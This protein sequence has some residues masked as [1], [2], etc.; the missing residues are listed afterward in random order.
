[1]VTN[2]ARDRILAEAGD[3][4]V[5]HGASGVT[6]RGLAARIG[7][8]PMALYRHFDSRE[9]LLRA[10]VEEGHSTFLGYLSRA[11]AEPTP[12]A[13]FL[14]S[15]LEYLA[16]ALDHPRKYAVM[17]MEHVPKVDGEDAT[18]QWLDVATFR[19]LV[20]RIRDCQA[21]SALAAGDP[22][23]LGLTVW[24]HVHGLVSLFLAGKICVDREAFEA[25]YRNSIAVLARGF[26]WCGDGAASG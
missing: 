1:M 17:F 2:L 24:A 18:Q 14:Q 15:G 12:E 16:F 13:R 26:G 11:L 7:V 25:I 21:A 6:M 22:E 8:T 9:A 19:F 23:A 20:D 5:A 3:L 4:F 10:V